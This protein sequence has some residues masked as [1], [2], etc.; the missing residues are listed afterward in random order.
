MTMY[1]PSAIALPHKGGGNGL[2][3]C[4]SWTFP[5]LLDRLAADFPGRSYLAAQHL[6]RGDDALRLAQIA[7]LAV[8]AGV[9]LV[10]TN[11][12]HAHSRERRLLQD[13]LTCIRAGCTIDE[14]GFRLFARSEEHTSELQSLMRISYAVF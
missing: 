14:A 11:D 1:G 3:L 12:V 2:A 6:Y 13:V 8:R 5:A 4:E 9:P 7:D 10:A